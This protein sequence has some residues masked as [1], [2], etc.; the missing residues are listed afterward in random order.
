M[1]LEI[2]CHNWYIPLTFRRP[3]LVTQADKETASENIL[4]TLTSSFLKKL[5][6]VR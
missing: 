4:H 6:P 5:R 2:R 3:V 1:R